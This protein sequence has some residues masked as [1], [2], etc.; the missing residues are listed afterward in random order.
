[1]QRGG[2]R[3]TRSGIVFVFALDLP[4]LHAARFLA[5]RVRGCVG[6]VKVGLE[7]FVEAGPEGVTDLRFV[8]NP[9]KLAFAAGQLS[10]IGGL[11]DLGW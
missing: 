5:A 2:E 7:L 10:R 6:F 1:M 3:S 8:M 4:D 11:P 9:D